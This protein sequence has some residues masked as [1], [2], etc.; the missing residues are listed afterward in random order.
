MTLHLPFEVATQNS[1]PIPLNV[2][3]IRITFEGKTWDEDFYD[4]LG[5]SNRTD[6]LALAWIKC[7]LETSKRLYPESREWIHRA[8]DLDLESR[9]WIHRAYDGRLVAE[10]G[11]PTG[12]RIEILETT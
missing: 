5:G 7:K 3:A 1:Y 12:I 2:P 10:L 4:W 9:E 8:S 11:I 6:V